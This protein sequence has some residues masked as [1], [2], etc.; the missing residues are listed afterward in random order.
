MRRRWGAVFEAADLGLIEPILVGPLAKIRSVAASIGK[1]SAASA[2]STQPT[3]TPPPKRRWRWSG[4]A[5][6]R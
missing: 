1:D 2:W 5:R 3:A 4:P 6:P